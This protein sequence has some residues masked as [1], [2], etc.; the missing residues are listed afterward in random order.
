MV[1]RKKNCGD[2]P[3]INHSIMKQGLCSSPVLS[4]PNLQHP[5]EIDTCALDY[6]VGETLTQHDHLVAYHSKTIS[7]VIHKYPT[8][9]K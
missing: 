8:Y 4:L 3:N 7:Y 2:Y 1:V 5:F 6:V 9:E